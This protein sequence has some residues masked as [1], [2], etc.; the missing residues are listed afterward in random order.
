MLY[1]N[2]KKNLL[3]WLWDQIILEKYFFFSEVAK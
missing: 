2:A 3:L 1:R